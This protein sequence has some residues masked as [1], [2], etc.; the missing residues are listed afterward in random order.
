[1]IWSALL[2]YMLFKKLSLFSKDNKSMKAKLRKI[3][4]KNSIGVR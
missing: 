4:A 1:M 3:K 2:F